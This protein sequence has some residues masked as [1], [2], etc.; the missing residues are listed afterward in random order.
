[1][2]RTPFE[3][4]GDQLNWTGYWS[5]RVNREHRIAYKVMNESLI[6]VPCRYHY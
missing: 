4:I 3:G 5:R 1:M 2:Q 6:I